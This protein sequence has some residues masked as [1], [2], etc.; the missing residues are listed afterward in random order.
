MRAARRDGHDGPAGRDG[1]GPRPRVLV[2]DD[3][4]ARSYRRR[5]T[6]SIATT[7]SLTTVKTHHRSRPL[8]PR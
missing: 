3:D 8:R 1:Q 7:L 2:V 6:Y 4:D 5:G